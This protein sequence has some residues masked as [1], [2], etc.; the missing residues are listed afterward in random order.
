MATGGIFTIITNDGKQDR[1]LMATALLHE[2]LRRIS[3]A[4]GG[5]MPSLLDIEKT[6]VLFTNAHFKPFAA[7][8]FEYNRVRASAGSVKLGSK[9]QFSIPQFGDFFHDIACHVVLTQPTLTSTA[10]TA[11]SNQPLMRWCN[12]PGERLLARVQQEVNGNPL[13]EYTY[14]ATNMHR[15]FRVAPN[16]LLSWKRCVGQEVAEKGWVKQPNG[17]GSGVASNDVKHRVQANVDTGDQTPTG[18][19]VGNL[20]LFIPLLFWYNKDVRLAVPSVAIPYGQRFINLELASADDLVGLVPRG[21]G[22]YAAPNGSLSEP[23]VTIELY[24]NNI[25]VNPEIHKIYIK[26]IGFSLIR[27][28]RQQIY[29]AS[30]ASDEVLLSQM[31]WPIEYLYVGM[32]V[33]DYHSSSTQATKYEHLDKW[34]MFSSVSDETY[35]TNENAASNSVLTEAD[36]I[37]TLGVAAPSAGGVSALTG[38]ATLQVD[39]NVGDTLLINGVYYVVETGAVLGAAV[40]GVS[41]YATAL[42]AVDTAVA[43]AALLVVAARNLSVVSQKCTPTM[44]TLSVKAHGIT[45]YDDFQSKFFNS[46]TTYH[47]GG[48]NINAPEDCGLLFV[49]FCLYPGTYQP[50]GH[51]NVSRAR[52]FYINYTSD[53]INSSNEGTL[54]VIASA[55]NFL[56]ISDGSAVLRYS[57]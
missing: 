52:E 44:K 19:K 11:S 39:V 47:F 30:K 21:S 22:T 24:I 16:K 55:I 15:E 20:E 12:F 26:R 5:D 33:R 34:N 2:R 41:V 43:A 27:V 40:T 13:D 1:M 14:H 38:T 28:H 4:K 46:Y 29:H 51:I 42:V 32:K 53:E 31:K 56:L 17:S 50:S 45:L 49:P 10:G 57:T 54:V 36:G 3:A 35:S 23:D 9:V 18:Q 25:F 48:P 7:I 8:G 6:H 37:V